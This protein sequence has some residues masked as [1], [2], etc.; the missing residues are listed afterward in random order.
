MVH[1]RFRGASRGRYVRLGIASLVFACLAAIPA[2][3]AAAGPHTC[4]GTS[5]KPG[6]LAGTYPSGV[7]VSGTCEVNA[8]QAHVEGTLTLKPNSVLIAAFGLN[9]RTKHGGSS[10]TVT[11]TVDVG[12]GATM[13][14]GCNPKSFPCI[15]DN[16]HKPKLTSRGA[17]SGNLKES[18]P[19]GVLV[20]SSRIGGSIAE[21]GGGGGLSCK[22]A[23]PFTL[24]KSPVYSD[25][26]D[27]TVIGSI[28]VSNLKTCWLGFARDH[29]VGHLTVTGNKVVD[30][31]AIEILSNTVHKNL[32]CS[33]NTRVWDSAETSSTPGVLFPRVPQPNIVDGKREGQCVLA[34]PTT[35]GGPAGPSP[36]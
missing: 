18:S 16:Q 13:V 24:F 2:V 1:S 35:M 21:N 11:G 5:K 12:R 10:L 29:V 19:L 8:G 34:S 36:F 3:A 28:S 31:D 23:G 20:H 27:N 15:D 33:G 30:P 17:I 14:L 6:V 26:E 4:S 7:V 9:H 22:P 25:Y 32:V